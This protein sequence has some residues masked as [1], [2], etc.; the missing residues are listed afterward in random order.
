MR[1]NGERAWAAWQHYQ[2]LF[3]KRNPPEERFPFDRADSAVNQ[4]FVSR[5]ADSSGD[6]NPLTSEELLARYWEAFTDAAP[7]TAERAAYC[8]ELMGSL[9]GRTCS[10]RFLDR[11]E[12]NK[13]GGFT[14]AFTRSEPVTV[15][16]SGIEPLFR[17]PH[18]MSCRIY[19]VIEVA[20]DLP[21]DET[22]LNPAYS[23]HHDNTYQYAWAKV[24]GI[25]ALE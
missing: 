9:V 18:N 21:F 16:A 22:N 5:H 20:T 24:K 14:Y 13:Q 10:I 3:P 25:T 6:S 23:N 4:L 19:P 2:L 11:M 7:D 1:N 17:D 12:P 8:L 15:V